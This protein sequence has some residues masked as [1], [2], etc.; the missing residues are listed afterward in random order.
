MLAA[1][2]AEEARQKELWAT[3]Q[4]S[5]RQLDLVRAGVSAENISNRT[6]VR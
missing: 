1:A 3:S 6:E 2:V 5:R 4:N